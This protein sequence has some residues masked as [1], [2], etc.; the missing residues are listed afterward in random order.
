VVIGL[1]SK[2]KKAGKRRP[3]RKNFKKKMK[4]DYEKKHKADGDK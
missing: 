3:V 1:V 4:A 2:E